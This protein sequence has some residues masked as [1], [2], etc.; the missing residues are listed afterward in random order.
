MIEFDQFTYAEIWAFAPFIA[1]NCFQREPGY[2]LGTIKSH[3]FCKFQLKIFKDFTQWDFLSSK[4]H[5]VYFILTYN[6]GYK[7]YFHMILLDAVNFF[8]KY[9]DG[10]V[11]I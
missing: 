6:C 1:H 2:S 8:N 11:I 9:E 10:V 7:K 3:I 4:L 5:R